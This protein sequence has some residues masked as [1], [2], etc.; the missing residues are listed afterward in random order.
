MKG[1]EHLARPASYPA[2][3]AGP[4]T[5]VVGEAAG[6]PQFDPD[7]LPCLCDPNPF[8]CGKGCKCV[9]CGCVRLTPGVKKRLQHHRKVE[10]KLRAKPSAAA[11]RAAILAAEAR[12]ANGLQAGITLPLRLG[13]GFN[14][15]AKTAKAESFKRKAERKKVALGMLAAQLEVTL[16]RISP[17]PKPLDRD[18]LVASL[19]ATQDQVAAWLRVDDGDRQVHFEHEQERGPWGVRIEVELV[20]RAR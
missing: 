9:G 17:S 6:G 15:A 2:R 18:N 8:L 1:F 19:K 20:G 4:N 13:R 5:L 7:I 3:A 10:A 11:K 12:E 16:T 14:T